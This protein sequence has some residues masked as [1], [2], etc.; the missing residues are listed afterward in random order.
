[1][2]EVIS[3]VKGI[4]EK[5]KQMS[6]EVTEDWGIEIESVEVQSVTLPKEVQESMHKLK[7]AQQ[8]KLAAREI[9]EGKKIAIEALQEAAGKLT[10]PTLQYLY[11]QSLQKIAEGKSSKIIFPLELSSL[12]A[13]VANRFGGFEKAQEKVSQEYESL[14]KKGLDRKKIIE[15]LKKEYGVA[16]KKAKKWGASK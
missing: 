14:A 4:T 7:E 16:E 1:L 15:E 5:L 9:A 2:A 13:R 10:D 8:R 6:R 12:A 11:L 3:N